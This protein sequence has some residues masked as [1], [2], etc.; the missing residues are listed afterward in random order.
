[1]IEDSIKTYGLKLSAPLRKLFDDIDKE[2]IQVGE[3]E[4][5]VYFF[6]KEHECWTT[7]S[8]FWMP[9]PEPPKDE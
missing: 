1:M 3:D 5:H 9:L 7:K 8:K 2:S 4:H 6:N